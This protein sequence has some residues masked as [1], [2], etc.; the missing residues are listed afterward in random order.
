MDESEVLE[1]SEDLIQI[2][3]KLPTIYQV[4][5]HLLLQSILSGE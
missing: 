5:M 2:L 1:Q 4:Q 3:D